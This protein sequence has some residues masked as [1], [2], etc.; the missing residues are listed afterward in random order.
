MAVNWKKLIIAGVISLF[1]IVLPLCIE[2]ATN[3][4]SLMITLFIYITLAQSWN[5][6]GGYAGQINLGLAAF[7]GCGVLITYFLETAGAPIL[8]S[9]ILGGMSAVVLAGIIGLPT[10]R[11]KGMYFS[12]GTLALAE[13]LRVVVNNVFPRAIYMSGEYIANYSYVSRYYLSMVVMAIALG[14][15]YFMSNSQTGLAMMA[16][17]DDASAAQVTGINK[18]KYEVTALFI[19]A[20][21]AGLAGGVYAFFRTSFWQISWV[22]SPHWTFEPLMAVAIGGASTLMGPIVGSIFL[23]ILSEVFALSLGEGHLI[24]FGLFF[25]LVVLFFP[26]GLVGIIEVVRGK[27]LRLMRKQGW[28]SNDLKS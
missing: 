1:F 22:F 10:L 7:F 15:V 27:I 13:A 12:I 26:H 11:L 4:I 2:S 23:V 24:L 18:F 19:S 17:R 20:F 14:T 25:I 21:L 6:M 16:V 5:I 9:L 28:G 3:V 8:I